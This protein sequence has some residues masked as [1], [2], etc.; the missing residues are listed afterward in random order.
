MGSCNADVLDTKQKINGRLYKALVTCN[1][2]DVVDLC[3]RISD[4]ALHVITV[5][6]DTVLHMVTYAKEAA[7]VERLLDYLPDHHVDKLT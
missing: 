3:Q 2:K 5:N 4:H 1:K 6:D 7:L